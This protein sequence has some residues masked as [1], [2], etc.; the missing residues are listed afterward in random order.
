MRW[1]G[2][3]TRWAAA[4]LF[5]LVLALLLG[6]SQVRAQ[7]QR[8]CWIDAKTGES[9]PTM[10]RQAVYIGPAE[11][12]GFRTKELHSGLD[13]DSHAHNPN[14]GENF[15]QLPNGE[16]IDSKTG[17]SV[18]TIPREALYAGL[19]SAAG[20]RTKELHLGLDDEN[21]ASNPNSGHN[22]VRVPCPEEPPKTSMVPRPG[23][24]CAGVYAELNAARADPA[25]YAQILRA[26]PQ[27]AA[28]VEAIA[29]LER[30]SSLPPL[31]P[32]PRLEAAAA[33][34]AADQG[35]G[36]LTGHT[37]T[38]GSTARDRI[39]GAGIF[40]SIIAEEIS[41]G[42]ADAAAVVRQLIIDEGSP[43]GMHRSD[44]FNPLVRFIGVGCGPH[45]RYHTMTVID[46]S[47]AIMAR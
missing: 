9:V 33:R 38:D 19:A 3:M 24:A 37:G 5:A 20:L 40:S 27:T 28:T 32:D 4:G 8:Y 43:G 44:L 35:P 1:R 46:L 42:Q 34:H 45:Q 10:P 36:G 12:A 47:G 26:G 25:H 31:T 6:P 18:A 23:A 13:D 29:F 7:D 30:Q 41:L 14:T 15:V 11:A 17:K 39:Q 22:F 16:W 21:H 2:P